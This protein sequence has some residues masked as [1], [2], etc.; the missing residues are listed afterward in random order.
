LIRV[1]VFLTRDKTEKFSQTK[2]PESKK[3]RVFC[4]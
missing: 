2:N 1:M 3:F 4:F